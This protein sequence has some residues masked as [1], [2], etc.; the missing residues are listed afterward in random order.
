MR[1][2]ENLISNDSLGRT[3]RDSN[4]LSVGDIASSGKVDFYSRGEEPTRVL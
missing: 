1:G 2:N 3:S 4:P